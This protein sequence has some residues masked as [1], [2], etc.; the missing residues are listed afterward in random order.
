MT[1]NFPFS[2][3]SW[4]GSDEESSQLRESYAG[5]TSPALYA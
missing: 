1:G 5:V 3:F 2:L 4:V